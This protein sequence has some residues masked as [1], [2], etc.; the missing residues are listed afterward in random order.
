MTREYIGKYRD[1]Y[2]RK[3]REEIR[4]RGVSVCARVVACSPSYL[5]RLGAG[6]QRVSIEKLTAIVDMLKVSGDLR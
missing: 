4:R 1:D 3:L 5:S 2:M 6:K